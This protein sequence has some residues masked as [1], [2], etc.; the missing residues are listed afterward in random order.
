MATQLTPDIKRGPRG[1]E[2]APGE[3]RCISASTAA[4]TAPPPWHGGSSPRAHSSPAQRPLLLFVN[5]RHPVKHCRA[6]ASPSALSAP[7]SSLRPAGPERG[8]VGT[9]PFRSGSRA[10]RPHPHKMFPAGRT[11]RPLRGTAA[12]V[13]T[14]RRNDSIASALVR[15][16]RDRHRWRQPGCRP[17]RRPRRGALFERQPAPDEVARN[18]AQP[19]LTVARPGSNRRASRMTVTNT[20]CVTSSASAGEPVRCRAKR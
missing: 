6:P 9:V 4:S 7:R 3:P 20:S 1:R 8:S 2:G 10:R 14:A 18:P 16:A 11:A 15:S 5:A 19:G 17:R 12:A 13:N